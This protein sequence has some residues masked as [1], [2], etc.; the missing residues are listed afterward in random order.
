MCAS[1]Y[2]I[3][4]EL[5]LKTDLFYNIP[6]TIYVYKQNKLKIGRGKVMMTVSIR[7]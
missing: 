2:K 4:Y 5:Y 6:R 7:I 1:D 3:H